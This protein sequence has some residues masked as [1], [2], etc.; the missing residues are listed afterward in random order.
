MEHC[1]GHTPLCWRGTRPPGPAPRIVPA[2]KGSCKA[3]PAAVR[4]CLHRM[5]CLSARARPPTRV[6]RAAL[7]APRCAPARPG[8]TQRRARFIPG[9]R[10]DD[11]GRLWQQMQKR[12]RALQQTPCWSRPWSRRLDS[13]GRELGELA[14]TEKPQL[15][16]LRRGRPP[17]GTPACPARRAQRAPERPGPQRRSAAAASRLRPL[18]TPAKQEPAAWPE[19]AARAGRRARVRL[20]Q[21]QQQRRARREQSPAR[22]A[23][24]S[25]ARRAAR[26]APARQ[27]GGRAGCRG[28]R[29]DRQQQR[30]GRHAALLSRARRRFWLPAALLVRPGLVCM[31][32]G[33]AGRGA[34][35]A[36]PCAGAHAPRPVAAQH[37]LPA[38]GSPGRAACLAARPAL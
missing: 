32:V 21:R 30:P 1:P 7:P 9:P 17:A 6:R 27:A 33:G 4:P 2:L 13:I 8:R 5:P 26:R 3:T 12:A 29:A 34:G 24:G 38:G 25:G 35:G 10:N 37:I 28:A 22:A 20:Q 16:R 14:L 11:P 36:W 19:R 15:S 23:A 18:A 31:V